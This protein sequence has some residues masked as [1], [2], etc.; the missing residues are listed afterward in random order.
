MPQGAHRTEQNTPQTTG[1]MDEFNDRPY[2]ITD[3]AALTRSSMRQR[4]FL[5]YMADF[6]AFDPDFDAP[7]A[8]DWAAAI[9]L[10]LMQPTDETNMDQ[11]GIHTADVNTAVKQ[12]RSTMADL[13]FFAQKAF[14]TRGL[15]T[16]FNFKVHD[17]MTRQPA[18]YVIYLRVQ[19]QLA[20]EFA[21]QLT[22]KGMTP[23]QIAAIATAADQLQEAEVAQ[24]KFKRTRLHL[25]LIRKDV[26]AR[27]YSFD[28]RVNRA[29]EVIY[30]EDELKRGLFRLD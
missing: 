12:A 4:V 16:V 24:E 8:Q 15:Y 23:A 10:G 27:M 6:V 19:H 28:Q 29:A 26:M 13:R 14:G 21:T 3:A 2:R 22:A 25:T 5:E 17:R 7:F 1:T 30:G 20:L 11:Q 9:E 18:S